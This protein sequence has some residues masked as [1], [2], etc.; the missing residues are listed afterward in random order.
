MRQ[1]ENLR[2]ALGFLVGGNIEEVAPHFRQVDFPVPLAVHPQTRISVA[3]NVAEPLALLGEAV[4]PDLPHLD[5]QGVANHLANCSTGRQQEIDKLVGRFVLIH[6]A[7]KD[8]L[9]IQTDAIGL[10]AV[11]FSVSDHGV[12]VGSHAQLVARA[13]SGAQLRERP[14]RWGYP[15]LSTAYTSVRRLP[16]NCELALGKGTLTRFFPRAVIPETGIERAWDVAFDRAGAVISALSERRKVLVSLTGGLDSRTTLAAGRDSW[17]HLTFFTY[18][19]GKREE[20]VD[21]NVATDL[22][23]RLGLRHDVVRYSGNESQ[24]IL[25]IVKDNNYTPHKPP[26]AGGYH[27]RFGEHVYLHVRSN[28]LE[29]ARSNLFYKSTRRLAMQDGPCTAQSMGT[30]YSHA[31]KLSPGESTHVVPAFE[32]YVAAADYESTLGLASPWDMYFVEHRMGAWQ[33]GVVLESDVSFNTVIAF[34]SR[35]IV[36][37]FMGVPQEIRCSS[38]H[39]A[40]RLTALLPEVADIPINPSQYPGAA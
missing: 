21:V 18:T 35:E 27:R 22:A 33:A 31:A 14:Y 38:A 13:G 19:R 26:V 25:G 4:H 10:R 28:L 15:G 16:P 39:L 8:D 5:L 12:V 24:T 11:F 3:D 36:R 32:D 37:T 30:L 34:N 17:S 23:R 20:R 9:R 7:T 2:Y 1:V 6:G 29:L 40:E